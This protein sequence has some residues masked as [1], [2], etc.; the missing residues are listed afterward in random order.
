MNKKSTVALLML[1]V[2]VFSFAFAVGTT[3]TQA[4]EICNCSYVCGFHCFKTGSW[5]PN[6]PPFGQCVDDNCGDVCTCY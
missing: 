5:I 4:I 6:P 3:T 1:A 2:F